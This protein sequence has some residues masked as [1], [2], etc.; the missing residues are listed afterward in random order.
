MGD[1][2][3]TGG[4]AYVTSIDIDFASEKKGEMFLS[5]EVEVDDGSIDKRECGVYL[6]LQ[7]S[8]AQLEAL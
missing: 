8:P 5:S 3:C 2:K 1:W 7:R 6:A 4:S